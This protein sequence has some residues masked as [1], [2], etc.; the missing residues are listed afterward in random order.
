[1]FSLVRESFPALGQ[2]GSCESF[3]LACKDHHQEINSPDFSILVLH[4][5]AVREEKDQGTLV[6]R[7]IRTQVA[8]ASSHV[9]CGTSNP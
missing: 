3:Y 6:C 8:F 1:M 7:V 4:S 2:N 9:V 5:G